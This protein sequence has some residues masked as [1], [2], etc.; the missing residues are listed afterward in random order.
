MCK[1]VVCKHAKMFLKGAQGLSFQLVS[2]LEVT[3]LLLCTTNST[4]NEKKGAISHPATKSPGEFHQAL[5]LKVWRHVHRFHICFHIFCVHGSSFQHSLGL[6]V[7]GWPCQLQPGAC[8]YKLVPT[9]LYLPWRILTKTDE[10]WRG[11]SKTK[12]TMT[13]SDEF[14]RILTNYDEN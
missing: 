8:T 12:C 9:S 5:K 7:D 4:L 14:W 1:Q 3:H 6:R 11:N 10:F 13:D 2:K